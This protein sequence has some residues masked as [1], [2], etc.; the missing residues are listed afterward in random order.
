MKKILKILLTI[1]ALGALLYGSIFFYT[2]LKLNSVKE[3]LLS[4]HP[5]ITKVESINSLGQW[6]EWYREFT[7]V[8]TIK[9][10]KYR[11]WTYDDGKITGKELMD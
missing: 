3:K 2:T 10:K 11:V 1:V 5:E 6:G 9:G 4:N 7:M 8:V